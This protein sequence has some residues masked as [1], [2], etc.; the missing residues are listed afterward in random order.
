[1][2]FHKNIVKVII[3]LFLFFNGSVYCQE[4]GNILENGCFSKYNSLFKTLHLDSTFIEQR[5][6]YRTYP[7]VLIDSIHYSFVNKIPFF[8]PYATFKIEKP[9]GTLYCIKHDCPAE[10]NDLRML[11]FV[12]YDNNGKLKNRVMLP[13]VKRGCFSSPNSLDY[14]VVTIYTAIDKIL[15]IQEDYTQWNNHLEETRLLYRIT[16]EAIPIL[17]KTSKK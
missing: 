5:I 1:M 13:C 6:Q 4:Q 16:D 3:L 17:I 12:T 14:T 15:F 8:Y 2:S 7:H 10:M 9:K 11:E